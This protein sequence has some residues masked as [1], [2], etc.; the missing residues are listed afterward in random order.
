M[1][2][3]S[4]LNQ[5]FSVTMP[6]VPPT[7]LRSVEPDPNDTEL[8]LLKVNLEAELHE[9][10]YLGT[11]INH[12][13]QTKTHNFSF[14]SVKEE[15]QFGNSDIG[16]LVW[17]VLVI[18]FGKTYEEDD[19]TVNHNGEE[20]LYDDMKEHKLDL[21]KNKTSIMTPVFKNPVMMGMERREN[22]VN[23]YTYLKR[24]EILQART[25]DTRPNVRYSPDTRIEVFIDISNINIDDGTQLFFPDELNNE[26]IEGNNIDVVKYDNNRDS[27]IEKLSE[28]VIR[29]EDIEE[30]YD[31]ISGDE[32]LVL[33]KCSYFGNSDEKIQLEY[34]QFSLPT[35]F[36]TNGYTSE[37]TVNDSSFDVI[38]EN[39][40]VL[41]RGFDPEQEFNYYLRNNVTG[42]DAETVYWYRPLINITEDEAMNIPLSEFKYFKAF[43]RRNPNDMLNLVSREN[44]GSPILMRTASGKLHMFRFYEWDNIDGDERYTMYIRKEL[45]SVSPVPE[46]VY[47]SDYVEINITQDSSVDNI[48][49]HFTM[50]PFDKSRESGTRYYRPNIFITDEQARNIPLELYSSLQSQAS[51]SMLRNTLLSDIPAKHGGSPILVKFLDGSVYIVRVY[52]CINQGN[53]VSYYRKKLIDGQGNVAAVVCAG[54]LYDISIVNIHIF[55]PDY[56]NI[57]QLFGTEENPM[58]IPKGYTDPNNKL[59]T[60]DLVVIP[61]GEEG[62]ISSKIGIF[63]DDIIV[64]NMNSYSYTLD[65][66]NID[67]WNVN[68]GVTITGGSISFE[69]HDEAPSNKVTI[70][71]I[72]HDQ[73]PPNELS[74]YKFKC[75]IRGKT[76]SGGDW[77]DYVDVTLDTC[78]HDICYDMGP[79]EPV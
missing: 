45:G 30:N 55:N 57:Y 24:G 79:A 54:E 33:L 66:F 38:D 8:N 77:T 6:L 25:L 28:V 72:A 37:I 69:P 50:F 60:G 61:E 34:S 63:N 5:T 9:L 17:S 36:D 22:T 56:K 14:L 41:R 21:T 75:G 2:A 58:V 15:S 73:I 7:N 51:E 64:S 78:E 76:H 13:E 52:Q 10:E 70:A 27:N 31:T 71:Q 4:G 59:F 62:G 32:I 44:G 18:T 39:K 19:L 49:E 40:L 23:F 16:Q 1:V 43:Y 74:N 42:D 48:N 29:F 67:S 12:D 46:F 3:G 47:D 35:S 11:T 68:D 65:N 53:T 20:R 26:S